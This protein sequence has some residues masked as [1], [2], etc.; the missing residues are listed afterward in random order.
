MALKTLIMNMLSTSA[1]TSGESSQLEGTNWTLATEDPKSVLFLL[2]PLLSSYSPCSAP[3]KLLIV[4]Q[5]PFMGCCILSMSSSFCLYMYL[6]KSL[7]TCHCTAVQESL[8]G[9]PYSFSLPLT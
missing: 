1:S 4:S 5:R 8:L 9:C 7:I 2:Y 6:P 3:S